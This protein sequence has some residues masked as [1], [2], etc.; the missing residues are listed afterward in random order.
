MSLR[1]LKSSKPDKK[2]VQCWQ[3]PDETRNSVCILHAS[4]PSETLNTVCNYKMHLYISIYISS[5]YI[6][7][8]PPSSWLQEDKQW[9]VTVGGNSNKWKLCSGGRTGEMYYSL[10]CLNASPRGPE[11]FATFV[12][13]KPNLKSTTMRDHQRHQGPWTPG[14]TPIQLK[15]MCMSINQYSSNEQTQLVSVILFMLS[16]VYRQ[17]N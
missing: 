5:L 11:V 14:I 4:Q 17:L 7:S 16:P 2:K 12:T 9:K 1:C 13:F 6:S 3:N 15:Q 8:S 10:S